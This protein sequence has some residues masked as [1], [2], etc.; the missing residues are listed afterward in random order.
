MFFL[1]YIEDNSCSDLISSISYIEIPCSLDNINLVKVIGV[2][3]IC[4]F[5]DNPN[6]PHWNV[7]FS[8]LRSKENVGSENYSS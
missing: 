5:I 6:E 2:T 8:P 1:I 3:Y 7:K 4:G